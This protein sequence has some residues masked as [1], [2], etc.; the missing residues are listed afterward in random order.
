MVESNATIAKSQDAEARSNAQFALVKALGDLQKLA[1]P[2]QRI[3]AR[4]DILVDDAPYWTGVWSSD[5]DDE[6]YTTSGDQ[7]QAE[8]KDRGPMKWLVSMQNTGSNAAMTAYQ[9]RS[10]SSL[11]DDEVLMT[12]D[13]I[14]GQAIILPKE[15][16]V[17]DGVV[18]GHYAYWVSDEGLKASI[19]MVPDDGRSNNRDAR[20]PSTMNM[21]AFDGVADLVSDPGDVRSL[22]GA[23]N[24][25]SE[26][27]LA[28]STDDSLLL[29]YT[30]DMTSQS[31][32]LPVNVRDA[33]LKKDLSAAF[34]D[35]GDFQ[36]L[37]TFHGSS[38]VFDAESGVANDRD[39]GG[40]RWEQLRSYYNLRP[41]EDGELVSRE[42]TDTEVGL[43]PV[44]AQFSL[45]HH[46][47]V[48][49]VGSGQY[50]PRLCVFPVVVLWNPYNQP[51]AADTYYLK[52]TDNNTYD[53]A[54][55][56]TMEIQSRIYLEEDDGRADTITYTNPNNG[57]TSYYKESD[58]FPD[59]SD[60][61]RFEISSPVIEP[62]EAIVFSPGS[63]TE[64]DSNPET[65]MPLELGFRDGEFFYREGVSPYHLDDLGVS[66]NI[67]E[68][69]LRMMS[70]NYLR[71][72]LARESVAKVENDELLQH[73]SGQNYFITGS[74]STG[75]GSVLWPANNASLISSAQSNQPIIA[76]HPNYNL[77]TYPA[78][79]AY[80]HLK[81]AENYAEVNNNDDL[82]DAQRDFMPYVKMIANYNPR[83]PRSTKSPL[84]SVDYGNNNGSDFAFNPNYF[85]NT[86]NYHWNNGLPT[87]NSYFA[88]NHGD[89]KVNFSYSDDPSGIAEGGF[90]LYEAPTDEDYFFSIADL[91]HA[92]LSQ[93]F[94]NP[95]K[96]FNNPTKTY[97][98][99][100]TWPAYAIGN[101][102]Q[103]PRIPAAQTSR[104]VWPDS[105]PDPIGYYHYDVSYL[106]NDAL[107][108]AYFFSA[109]NVADAV[110]DNVR[111]S[112][113]DDFDFGWD[114]SASSL[115]IEG[116]FNVNSTSQRAW[117]AF[118]SSAQV[119]AVQSRAGEFDDDDVTPF[120]RVS[121]PDG[122]P[123]PDD[124]NTLSDEIYN[125]FLTLSPSDIDRLATAIV[126][127]VKQRGPFISLSHFV[128][129]V[130]AD[131]DYRSEREQEYGDSDDVGARAMMVGALQAAIELSEV[132]VETDEGLPRFNDEA[133]QL[134]ETE[135]SQFYRE[136]DIDA[137]VGD[138]AT[139]ALGYLTQLD[140]L[141]A[142]GPYISTRSDTFVIH[143][144]GESINP[145]SGEVQA[146]ARCKATVQ[147]LAQYV[148]ANNAATDEFDALTTTNQNFGRQF[149]IID[150]QWID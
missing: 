110:S 100:N 134:T 9:N 92:N 24:H 35:A 116:A 80:M 76:G 8:I 86:E 97:N 63:I 30:H 72:R 67:N 48:Y 23:T 131:G 18:K 103:D 69:G 49:S 64:W 31:R 145:L 83:A 122:D 58:I 40:P 130:L 38:Q 135:M 7:T 52:V 140:L 73:V 11:T 96:Y 34:S 27:P 149:R 54:E 118:L 25:L 16:I 88:Y 112:V 20:N 6:N 150:F 117:K 113:S 91:A 105:N 95:N 45:H 142:I 119:A 68:M 14:D 84:E 59:T 109:Y 1:G 37:I 90:I 79:G 71:L 99:Q 102:L 32:A 5:P 85:G 29:D 10:A 77:A 60:P 106:L 22:L 139:G 36:D 26:L 78:A 62:G 57:N 74:G 127:Q 104:S 143:A 81:L 4:A 125:G 75:K 15:D 148:D 108:D 136:L 50:Q 137:S 28:L 132:N 107:W 144:Y 70:A 146:T 65:P 147:R 51:I 61:M 44:I 12:D 17:G 101:S 87:N 43:Y 21:S 129:R 141:D 128:N 123:T 19:S 3:T 133:F 39:P 98:A 93:P 56:M 120:L 115:F 114:T 42:Q 2:D 124:R 121:A 13:D 111:Y 82:T 55:G 46:L 41:N 33:G 94:V 138:R 126:E 53:G 47:M 66:Q 89:E